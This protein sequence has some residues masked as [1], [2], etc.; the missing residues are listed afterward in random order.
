MTPLATETP[1]PTATP[2]PTET[3]APTSTPAPTPTAT[4]TVVLAELVPTSTPNL[5][6]EQEQIG[7]ITV[8][9]FVGI[10]VIIIVFAVRWMIRTAKRE[11]K[12]V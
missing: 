10:V 8:L 12:E 4:I 11:P 1:V 2:I 3:A 9:I 7:T 6:S 5:T